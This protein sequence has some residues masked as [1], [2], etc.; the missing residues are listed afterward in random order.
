[1]IPATIQDVSCFIKETYQFGPE[2]IETML[3][4]FRE[5]LKQEFINAETGLAQNNS[6]VVWRAAHT[7]KGALLNGGVTEWAEFAR[8]IELSAKNGE[9]KDYKQL[10]NE[11]KNGVSGI[12]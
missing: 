12:L 9:E 1:M 7:I 2:Q 5:S 3:K 11:L 4:S 8:K 6:T 10:F